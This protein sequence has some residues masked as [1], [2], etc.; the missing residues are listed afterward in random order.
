[1]E[2]C[3]AIFTDKGMNHD[4]RILVEDDKIISE[5]EKIFESLNKLFVDVIINLFIPQYE[6]LTSNIN[7]SDDPV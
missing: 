4:K 2:N 6:D 3:E 1:M 5:N 7:G